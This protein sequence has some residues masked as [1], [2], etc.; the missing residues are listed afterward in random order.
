[1]ALSEVFQFLIGAT[2]PLKT[3]RDVIR[4]REEKKKIKEELANALEIETEEFEEVNKE[5]EEFGGKVLSLVE[6]VETQPTP[7]QVLE[8]ID[9][10]SGTPRILAK[11]IVSFIHLAK[12]CKEISDQK[13][14]MDSLHKNNRFMY[15]FIQNMSN[16][17]VKKNT[18]LIDGKFFRFFRVYKKEIKPKKIKIE[19]SDKKE[20]ETIERNTEALLHNLSGDF[21]KRH[22]RHR[23]IKKWKANLVELNKVSQDITVEDADT[24]IFEELVPYKLR[25]FSS[26]F[27]KSP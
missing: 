24:T 4:S 6:Q 19:N 18:V 15:D 25:Q 7:R 9:C 21:L 1:V 10:L 8:F 14:F 13:G 22:M 12:A 2:G 16:T 5:F 17:Y 3:L 20:I 27:D 26:F 11:F 23:I